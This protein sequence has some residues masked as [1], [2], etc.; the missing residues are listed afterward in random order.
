MNP[1]SLYHDSYYNLYHLCICFVS[2]SYVLFFCTLFVSVHTIITN[3]F[4]GK[5]HYERLLF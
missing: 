4:S 2:I 5:D 3:E 1:G